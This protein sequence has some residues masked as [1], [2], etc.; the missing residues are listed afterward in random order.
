MDIGIGRIIKG[1]SGVHASNVDARM[2]FTIEKKMMQILAFLNRETY[3]K[4][5]RKIQGGKLLH[6]KNAW[7]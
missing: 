6:V 3:D 1:E 7:E 4:F 5:C 2:R